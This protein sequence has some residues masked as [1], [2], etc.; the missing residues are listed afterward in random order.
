MATNPKP[1]I[2]PVETI[3]SILSKFFNI[4]K[5]KASILKGDSLHYSLSNEYSTY[6]TS[7]TKGT[8]T[9]W[10]FPIKE[11]L[12]SKAIKYPIYFSLKLI[13]KGGFQIEELNIK[14]FKENKSVDR[15]TAF[16]PTDLLLRVEWSNQEQDRHAQPHW[17]IHSYEINN[18]LEDVKGEDASILKSFKED[19]LKSEPTQTSLFANSLTEPIVVEP[20]EVL[21]PDS[22][23]IPTFKFHLSM[24]A[25]WHKATGSKQNNEL[26]NDVLKMWLP[27]CLNYIKDQIEY[28]LEKMS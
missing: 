25:D 4:T 26:T 3:N 13:L 1:K 7:D 6:E 19:V 11:N 8:H 17:H 2:E 20:V 5:N 21:Q 22:Y 16:L 12:K 9:L 14:L 28:I 24:L 10:D 18:F 15:D 27:Q 23:E